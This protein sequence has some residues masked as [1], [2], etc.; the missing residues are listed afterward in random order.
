[1]GLRSERILITGGTGFTGRLLAR[2]LRGDGHDVLAPGPHATAETPAFDLCTFEPI[3][4][5]LTRFRPDVIVHLAGIAATQQSRPGQL[6]SVNVVGTANL[7]A[8]LTSA[9]L[10]PR[11]MLVA[12]SAQV[13]APAGS[14]MLLTEASPLGPRSHYGISK[15][16]AEEIASIYAHD[17]PIVICRAFNYTGPG[18]TAEFLVPKIVQHYVQRRPEI[19]LGNLDLNR[20]LSDVDRVVEAYARL[21][22]TATASSVVNI[23]SGRAVHL[24]DI[25]TIMDELSGYAMKVVV[26]P[27][28]VR[29]DEPRTLIGSP[30]R[31]EAL[32]GPLP[33]REFRETL[34]RMY[35]QGC[36]E[37]GGSGH[38]ASGSP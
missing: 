12:S 31:L 33:H 13:Y 37:L 21:V 2:R 17:I 6:Y 30:E 1:M 8:A 7:F 10:T 29:K 22:S 38:V 32:V 25:V 15:H 19:R 4:G 5:E 34:M 16:A 23:C 14:S 36:T 26:D 24:A 18:Q 35:E 9:N 20:D 11:L 27:A 28:L 3:A